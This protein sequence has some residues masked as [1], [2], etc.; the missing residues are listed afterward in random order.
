MK[1]TLDVNLIQNSLI[2]LIEVDPDHQIVSLLITRLAAIFPEKLIPLTYSNNKIQRIILANNFTGKTVISNELLQWL[3]R[4]EDPD[5]INSIKSSLNKTLS[6]IIPNEEELFTEIQQQINIREKLPT[7]LELLGN[8]PFPIVEDIFL[9]QWNINRYNEKIKKGIIEGLQFYSKKAKKIS[10]QLEHLLLTLN[11]SS[12]EDIGLRKRALD[13]FEWLETTE[14]NNSLDVIVE[15]EK[16]PAIRLKAVKLIGKKNL[17]DLYPILIERLKFDSNSKIRA[18]AAEALGIL[19]VYEA[20][21]D[22]AESLETD[23]SFSVR[24]ASAEAL[25]IIKSQEALSSLLKGLIDEDSYVRSVSAWSIQQL[26]LD[27]AERGKLMQRLCQ[28]C[29]SQEVDFKV[30]ENIISLLAQ[31]NSYEESM[32]CLIDLYFKIQ[33]SSLKESILEGLESFIPLLKKDIEFLSK[34]LPLILKNLQLSIS[35]SLKASICTFLGNLKENLSFEALLECLEKES[36]PWVKRQA[37]WAISQLDQ[38]IFKNHILDRIKNSRDLLLNLNY[39]E[40]LTNWIEYSDLD[41]MFSLLHSDRL[42][43]RQQIIEAFRVFINKIDD[44][45]E[46]FSLNPILERLIHHLLHDPANTVRAASAHALGH[47][48]NSDIK[49]DQFLVQAIQIEK[50]YS[51][52]ELAAE[53]LGYRSNPSIVPELFKLIDP[54]I[55]KDPSIRYF[56][57]LSLLDILESQLKYKTNRIQA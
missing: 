17:Y 34:Y 7:Y 31:L 33:S 41:L 10:K 57:C 5:V 44:L 14:V 48:P 26:Y 22:L 29:L 4:E 36:D 21:G 43:V 30:K 20:L 3:R 52:R 55:E 11:S 39:L 35:F 13:S 47:I 37:T 51:V 2:N 8:F 16:H 27:E 32:A 42:E 50:I 54:Q 23:V 56:S 25:G 19:K 38:R 24:E 18:A 6:G 12:Y 9:H 53:A 46:S 40:I 1:K 15:T 49:I 28:T 45:D